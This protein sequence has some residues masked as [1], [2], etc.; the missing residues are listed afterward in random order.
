MVLQKGRRSCIR[1]GEER[2]IAEKPT[3][4]TEQA[5]P[6]ISV[7]ETFGISHGIRQPVIHDRHAGGVRVSEPCHLD[8]RRLSGKGK[9]TV[10]GEMPGKVNEDVN[11]V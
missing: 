9:Q 3:R 2:I 6:D 5:F 1:R 4:E 10:F 8:G 7:G 11:A